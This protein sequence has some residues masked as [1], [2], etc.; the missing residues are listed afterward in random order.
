MTVDA[1]PEF[2][3][4]YPEEINCRIEITTT[5]G[6]QRVAQTAHPKGHPRNPM[7]DAEINSK[8]R[9]LTTELLTTQ[10]CNQALDLLWSLEDQPSLEELYDNLVI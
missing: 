10:Q 3:R 2:S 1:E 7:S 8:F 5:S 9:S 6:E 4:R